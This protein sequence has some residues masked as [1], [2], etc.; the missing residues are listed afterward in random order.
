MPDLLTLV[1][2]ETSIIIIDLT[3]VACRVLLWIFILRFGFGLAEIFLK[4]V[5]HKKPKA[6][7]I[8]P[9]EVPADVLQVQ[10]W[11]EK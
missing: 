3:S 9:I 5:A 2:P 4:W 11:E 1:S 7:K 6:Q 10:P 8:P